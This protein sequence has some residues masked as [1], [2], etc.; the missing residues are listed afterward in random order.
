LITIAPI[1]Q[2]D[3]QA[4]ETLLDAAF[5]AD[6]HERTAY[7]LR[8]RVDAIPELSFAAF[9]KGVLVG[10][11]LS[12]P[13]EL[14]AADGRVEPL[15]LVGPVAVQPG[16]QRGGIGKRLMVHALAAA[17]ATG[18]DALVLIG[19]PEYYDRFFGFT[20]EATG[21]WSVPGPVE[22]RRLLAR[23]TNG[24]TLAAHGTLRPSL[25]AQT[26]LR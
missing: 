4:V 26:A 13:I 7:K 5:G 17:D 18:E 23:L 6:R 24:R 20:A 14:A 25:T 1:A 15:V 21:G 11:L 9:D 22:R 3:P 19:D 2:A 8:R 12:W 16:R 10:A